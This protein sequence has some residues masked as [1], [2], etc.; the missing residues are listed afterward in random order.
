MG[1]GEGEDGSALQGA[2]VKRRQDVQ[3]RSAG[4]KWM[5]CRGKRLDDKRKKKILVITL[6]G[7]TR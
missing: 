6:I 3:F 7:H 1:M 5:R 2:M 4:C